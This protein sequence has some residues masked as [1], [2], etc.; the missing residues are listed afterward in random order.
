VL[1]ARVV[2]QQVLAL[3]A[4]TAALSGISPQADIHHTG[5][6]MLCT[7]ACNQA[8]LRTG[9]QPK[10]GRACSSAAI[11]P[12]SGEVISW[13]STGFGSC[14]LSVL[15]S[16][17]ISRAR[18]RGQRR[19]VRAAARASTARA[20]LLQARSP[21]LQA[22]PAGVARREEKEEHDRR[23][24]QGHLHAFQLTRSR[25]AGD[26]LHVECYTW[27]RPARAPSCR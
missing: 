5:R 1:L 25:R 24:H 23:V 11:W 10:G 26:M 3:L 4:P 27:A 8:S 15:T 13:P 7:Q 16:A 19:V 22:Q 12:V 2:F 14:A 9:K 20:R 18:L 21:P 6:S 17:G